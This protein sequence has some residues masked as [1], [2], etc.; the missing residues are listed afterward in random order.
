MTL[1][2]QHSTFNFQHST[3]NK[4]S[5]GSVRRSGLNVRCLLI[6]ITLLA[7]T[8][9]SL[10]AEMAVER[11]RLVR[12][13]AQA[14]AAG[15]GN[16]ENKDAHTSAPAVEPFISFENKDRL[17]G[18]LDHATAETI[19]WRHKDSKEPITFSTREVREV[20][21]SAVPSPR[22]EPLVIVTLTN[23]DVLPCQAMELDAE[24]LAIETSC[25][26]KM[27]VN[28]H[29]LAEIRP[30]KA[31]NEKIIYDLASSPDGWKSEDG[32]NRGGDGKKRHPV[33]N[34]V[35]ELRQGSS[36]A[37]DVGLPEM[38]AID[39]D[40]AG[41]GMNSNVTI[42]F[43]SEAFAR[44][45][46]DAYG[47]G[48][49]PHYLSFQTFSNQGNNSERGGE[50]N[51][52]KILKNKTKCHVT[53]LADRKN[54]SFRLL[55]N[56]MQAGQWNAVKDIDGGTILGFAND[57]QGTIRIAK[58]LVSRWNGEEFD[59]K[60]AVDPDSDSVILGNGDKISGTL[61]SICNGALTMKTDF[62]SFTISLDRCVAVRT[63][64]AARWTPRLNAADVKVF[65]GD[66]AWVTV[67]LSD[68]QN[69]RLVGSGEAFG[70]ATLDLAMVRRILF[71][72]HR[73]MSYKEEQARAAKKKQANDNQADD[74]G[75]GEAE[76]GCE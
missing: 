5:V 10:R 29:M 73:M 6:I 20:S 48:L 3:L 72:P 56:G 15:T 38:A 7:T 32:R 23:G 41:L 36:L 2:F 45:R 53:L 40:L 31:V 22:K 25:A 64:G 69:G 68:I 49:S 76:E 18:S 21:F 60:P 52:A 11:N 57:S 66:S 9:G 62:A 12:L 61:V 65:L 26:G 44:Y 46:G 43:Y 74:G 24:R 37:K 35:I 4:F 75:E 14:K 58:L 42:Y 8:G 17:H 28:R 39:F 59:A 51:I 34:G 19:F 54:R 67:K 1:N 27:T 33:S 30:I 50:S 63:A 70:A 13:P 71:K 16:A 55:V 47:I